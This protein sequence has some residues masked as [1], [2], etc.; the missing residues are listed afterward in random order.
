MASE[1]LQVNLANARP[2]FAFLA[3][4]LLKGLSTKKLKRGVNN[5]SRAQVTGAHVETKPRSSDGCL[6][7]VS[8]NL[9]V[10]ACNTTHSLE[11]PH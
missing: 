2:I 8:F 5:L 11:E 10:A 1:A 3:Y 7:S 9:G 4:A 6:A